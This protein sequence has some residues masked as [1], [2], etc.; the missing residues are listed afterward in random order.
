MAI[1][2]CFADN[3]EGMKGYIRY[4]LTWTDTEGIMFSQATGK[5]GKPLKWMNLGDW[6]QPDKLP[7][8]DMVHTFYLWRCAELTAMSAKVLGKMSEYDEYMKLA[9][10]TKQAFHTRFYD[11]EKG[12]Y[13][14]FGGNIFALKMGVPD[15]QKEK[16]IAALKADIICKRRTS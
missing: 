2:I 8:D 6:S 15:D 7:P 1:R 16:V 4:M 9:E 12:S 14:K 13:G 3:Y 11:K 5:D 10:K